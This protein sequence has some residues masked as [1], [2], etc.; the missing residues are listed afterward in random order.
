[1]ALRNRIVLS[2]LGVSRGNRAS[3]AEK[4]QVVAGIRRS[5]SLHGKK[6]KVAERDKKRSWI[7]SSLTAH[8]GFPRQKRLARKR[9]VADDEEGKRGGKEIGSAQSH[10]ARQLSRQFRGA[11]ITLSVHRATAHNLARKNAG[12]NGGKV[13]QWSGQRRNRRPAARQSAP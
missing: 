8:H 10:A 5:A 1:M 11:K 3:R 6:K 2:Y 4:I 7:V 12:K 9:T 13:P